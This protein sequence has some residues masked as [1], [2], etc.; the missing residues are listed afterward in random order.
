M[1]RDPSHLLPPSDATMPQPSPRTALEMLGWQPFFAQQIGADE[2]IQTPPVRVIAVHRSGLNVRG[3]GIETVLLPR[4]DATA[5]DWILFNAAQPA[6][7]VI[8]P[9]K[10]LIQRRAPG[11]DRRHQLIAANV[12]TC[13]IVTSC[14]QDFNIA[15]LERYVALAFEAEVTP[16]IILTKA[17]RCDDP[18]S[19]IEAASAISDRVAIVVLNALSD[20]PREKLRPWCK[21]GQTV[22]FLGSSGVGK[23]TLV[24][25]LFGDDAIETASVREDDDKGRHTTRHRQLHFLPDGCA[26]MDTPGMRELQLAEAQDGVEEVF[27]DLTALAE[28]CRFRNCKHET[29]PGCA[30]RAALNADVFDE[31]R[32]ARWNKLAAEEQANTAAMAKRKSAG[33]ALHKTIKSIQKSNKK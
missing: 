12:D 18:T 2:M 19:F 4:A 3:D 29:E 27:S 16:V 15:R 25:A 31:A 14:N 21:P 1:T 22:A 6:L 26:V 23:S 33:K 11:D 13:F 5:G 32:L 24:N 28:Q 17:D 8:L 30:I 10:S 20:E 7:S 9:R